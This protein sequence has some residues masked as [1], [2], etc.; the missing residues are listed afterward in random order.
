METTPVALRMAE[1]SLAAA[2][3]TT[4]PE[5]EALLRFLRQ[6]YAYDDSAQQAAFARCLHLLC[7]E[8]AALLPVA[9]FSL[10]H[11]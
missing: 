11:A 7:L 9:A 8:P 5:A 10:A 1:L 4:A 3:L 6:L 2:P